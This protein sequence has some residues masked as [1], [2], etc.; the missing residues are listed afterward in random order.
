MGPACLHVPF[1]L[2][3]GG[4]VELRPLSGTYGEPTCWPRSS[5]SPADVGNSADPLIFPVISCFSGPRIE[6]SQVVDPDPCS[7]PDAHGLFAK[8]SSGNPSGR[9]R[10]IPNRRRQVPD[11]AARPL[12]AEALSDLLDRKVSSLAAA[13]RNFCRR[14]SPRPRPASWDRSVVVDA[15]LAV[16]RTARFLRSFAGRDGADSHGFGI[17]D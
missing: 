15:R 6:E 10:G 8:G 12:R 7:P 11:L 16:G 17:R 13:P 14:R 3:P 9:P 1:R 2:D 4:V 5:R